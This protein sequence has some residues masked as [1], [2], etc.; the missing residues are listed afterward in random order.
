MPVLLVSSGTM[1]GEETYK[2][3]SHLFLDPPVRKFMIYPA[4]LHLYVRLA[5]QEV[6]YRA[7]VHYSEFSYR[8]R[9]TDI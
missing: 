7:Q 2:P 6:L 1:T 4:A 9:S 8:V 3:P 5:P